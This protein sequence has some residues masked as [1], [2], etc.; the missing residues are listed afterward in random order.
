M[1]QGVYGTPEF[2]HAMERMY[3]LHYLSASYYERWLTATATLLVEKEVITRGDLDEA[4]EGGFPL[5]APPRTAPLR[6]PGPDVTDPRFGIGQ[7]AR[8]RN[9]HPHGHTRCPGYVRGKHGVV[10]RYDGPC[11]FDDVEAHSDAKRLE[12]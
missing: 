5:S 4:V 8:V 9:A 2:R 3:P 12:P 6:D 11:N 1:A 10:V 7:R